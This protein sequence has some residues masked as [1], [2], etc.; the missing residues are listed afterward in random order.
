MKD[1]GREGSWRMEEE[2][3][4][5]GCEGRNLGLWLPDPLGVEDAVLRVEEVLVVDRQEVLQVG[6]PQGHLGERPYT[7]FFYT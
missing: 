3:D 7:R 2:K 6:R 5:G 1:G 4:D